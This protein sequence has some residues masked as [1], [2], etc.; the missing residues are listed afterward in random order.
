MKTIKHSA[1]TAPAAVGGYCQAVEARDTLRWL[2]ISG[3]IPES[4]DG[5]VPATF[6]QQARLVWSHIQAQLA[7]A[8]MSFGNLMK[9]TTFLSSREYAAENRDVR[10]AVLGSHTPALTVV[11]TGIFDERWLL[12]IEAIAAA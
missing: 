4:R 6:E 5:A 1:Q 10:Q 9:V 2:F 3:Q 8:D 12:E 7:A 11:I